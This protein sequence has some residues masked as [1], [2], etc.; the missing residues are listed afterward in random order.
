[1]DKQL[2]NADKTGAETLAIEYSIDKDQIAERFSILATA[3]QKMTLPFKLTDRSAVSNFLQL[4]HDCA[5]DE[6]PQAEAAETLTNMYTIGS[7]LCLSLVA[8]LRDGVGHPGALLGKL[9]RSFKQSLVSAPSTPPTSPTTEA[10]SAALLELLKEVKNGAFDMPNHSTVRDKLRDMKP[11]FWV[12][13]DGSLYG[14]L[15]I[16]NPDFDVSAMTGPLDLAGLHA[17]PVK[18]ASL[19]GESIKAAFKE[20]STW[21][22]VRYEILNHLGAIYVNTAGMNLLRGINHDLAKKAGEAQAGLQLQ[23]ACSGIADLEADVIELKRKGKPSATDLIC[24]IDCC[25]APEHLHSD[26]VIW[27]PIKLEPGEAA[28][29]LWLRVR[30]AGSKLNKSFEE[31]KHKMKMILY[32][33]AMDQGTSDARAVADTFDDKCIGVMDAAELTT[34]LYKGLLF[35]TVLSK[36]DMLKAPL[37]EPKASDLVKPKPSQ[38][39]LLSLLTHRSHATGRGARARRNAARAHLQPGHSADHPEGPP[40]T[41]A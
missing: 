6:I 38:P 29:T 30:V 5:I 32:K 34:V 35:K 31:M 8:Y 41:S 21:P 39:P 27:D 25:C 7:P 15:A 2:K 33:A 17:L 9:L 14:A 24:A 22:S 40:A 28:Y 36:N 11:D 19:L 10:A 12:E 37:D 18:A 16:P 23:D 1:M 3:V 20:R 13:I 4:L 26:M